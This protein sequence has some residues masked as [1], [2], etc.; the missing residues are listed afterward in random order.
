MINFWRQ[1]HGEDW[2]DIFK[3][4]SVLMEEA[5]KS[6]NKG[7][8]GKVISP[9]LLTASL[10]GDCIVDIEIKMCDMPGGFRRRKSC[11]SRLADIC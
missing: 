2:E 4:D 7:D 8:L 10:A 3:S 6:L 9:V 1:A 11:F 5:D